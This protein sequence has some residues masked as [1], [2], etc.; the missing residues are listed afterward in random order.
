MKKRSKFLAICLALVCTMAFVGCGKSNDSSKSSKASGDTYTV[1]VGLNQNNT[2]YIP[3]DADGN[4]V[5]LFPSSMAYYLAV[6]QNQ[7]YLDYTLD[8]DDKDYTLTIVCYTGDPETAEPYTV[9][10]DTGIA[11]KFTAV[12]KGKVTSND[13]S[14]IGLAAADDVE[15][16]ALE[17]DQDTV[18]A[19]QMLSMFTFA[20]ADA[21]SQCG[22]WTS[23]DTPE[24][25]EYYPAVNMS[26][27]DGAITGWTLAE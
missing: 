16:S 5:P 3:T 23:A 11:G 15:Y 27:S 17:K 24:L 6:N 4:G 14:T 25:L 12:A 7:F 8:V 18:I 21:T 20:S 2:D 22:T 13:G 9:G 26:V 1:L 10:D 19:E